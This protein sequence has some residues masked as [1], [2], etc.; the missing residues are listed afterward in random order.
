MA[1]N[2]HDDVEKHPV[3]SRPYPI[4]GKV[5]MNTRYQGDVFM[6]LS[7]W[8]TPP[9]I[10]GKYFKKSPELSQIYQKKSWGQAPGVPLSS[11]PGSATVSN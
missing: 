9:P 2:K 11:D 4:Y 1:W 6:V 7:Q 5:K 3:H 8:R 10:L